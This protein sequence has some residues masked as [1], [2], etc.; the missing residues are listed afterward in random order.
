MLFRTAWI[1]SSH[2]KMF[3]MNFSI[4]LLGVDIVK[5]QLIIWNVLF[6]DT[7]MLAWEWM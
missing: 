7:S 3:K 4:F 1:F 2:H 6:S 5:L